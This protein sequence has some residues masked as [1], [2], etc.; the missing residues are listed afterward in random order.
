MIRFPQDV[1]RFTFPDGQTHIRLKDN[2][3]IHT[4]MHIRARIASNNDLVDFCSLI[5]LLRINAVRDIHVHFYYLISQR[6][7]RQISNRE[8]MT[9]RTIANI[10]NGLNLTSIDVFCPHSNATLNMLNG[11]FATNM[12]EQEYYFYKNAIVESRMFAHGNKISIVLPDDGGAKRWHNEF[13]ALN[14]LGD[15][16]ECS[17]KRDMATG[18]LSGFRVNAESVY[19]RCVIVDDLVDGGGTFVA[20]AKELRNKGAKQ[21]YLAAP[22]GIFSKGTNLEGIDRIYTTNSFQDFE[23]NDPN[24][25]KDYFTETLA[26][27]KL[28][29]HDVF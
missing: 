5:D 15:V 24:E 21:V 18:K 17:K 9:L 20:L 12:H 19:E 22:H 4:D 8:P 27:D 16:V 29:V 3:I 14:S 7:D 11:G 28:F 25:L 26:N 23:L 6:M 1:E 10:I 2:V 13:S